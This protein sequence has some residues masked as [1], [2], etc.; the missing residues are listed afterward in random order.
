MGKGKGTFDHWGTLVPAGKILFEV[1]A[2]GVRV[3]IIR[4]ALMKAGKAIPGPVQFVIKERLRVPGYCGLKK[5]P[6]FHAGIK[7]EGPIDK[8]VRAET[9]PLAVLSK[10]AGHEKRERFAKALIR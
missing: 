2:P 3:E 9:I 1:T 6:M 7:I 4:E 8:K 5:T 10:Q